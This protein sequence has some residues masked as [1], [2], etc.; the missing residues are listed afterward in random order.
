MTQHASWRIVIAAGGT[1]GHLYPGI[2]VARRFAARCPDTEVLFVGHPGGLEERLL[3]REG[4][5]LATVTVRALQGQSRLG[6]AQALGAL[7]SWH[8]PGAASPLACASASGRRGRRLRHGTSGAGRLAAPRAPGAHGA[9]SRPRA[10]SARSGASLLSVCLP[11]FQ[12]V[13]RICPAGR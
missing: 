12:R 6:Q 13:R 9:K 10:D 7:G 5:R 2:A 4:F 3:P 8:P 11:P 1:G